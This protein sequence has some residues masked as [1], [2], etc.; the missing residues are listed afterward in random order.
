M[1][2]C[3]SWPPLTLTKA[4][5]ATF[6]DRTLEPREHCTSHWFQRRL[7]ELVVL[8]NPC[9]ERLGSGSNLN[10]RGP[11]IGA[12]ALPWA[13]SLLSTAAFHLT[14]PQLNLQV[15][16]R[17]P[18][19]TPLQVPDARNRWRSIFISGEYPMIENRPFWKIPLALPLTPQHCMDIARY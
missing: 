9:G 15:T 18:A 12:S 1:I 19:G 2:L 11:T 6:K 4:D 13:L 10:L 5:L 8:K 14:N 3:L 17:A 16:L 7:L